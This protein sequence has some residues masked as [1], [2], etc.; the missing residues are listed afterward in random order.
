MSK[1]TFH[2][3][4]VHAHDLNFTIFDGYMKTMFYSYDN[5]FVSDKTNYNVLLYPVR[6]LVKFLCDVVNLLEAPFYFLSYLLRGDM[7]NVDL[8]HACIPKLFMCL[9]MDLVNACVS[10]AWLVTRFFAPQMQEQTPQKNV[11][12]FESC[13]NAVV[14]AGKD[15]VEAGPLSTLNQNV[16]SI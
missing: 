12:F 11:G 14:D 1:N 4:I 16:C 13:F 10:L 15:I 5:R 2:Q 9:A 7:Q 6:H 3:N 8:I